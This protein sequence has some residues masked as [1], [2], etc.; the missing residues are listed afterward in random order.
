MGT[1]QARDF[2]R[3][4]NKVALVTGAGSGIGR[5]TALEFS[6]EGARVAVVD[7]NDDAGNATVAAIRA[8]GGDAHFVPADVSREG[9]VKAMVA[10]VVA[11]YGRLDAAFNN[12]GVDVHGPLVTELDEATW[13]KVVDINLKGVFF[14]LKHEIPAMLEHGGGAIV[15]TASVGGVV[16]APRLAAY[17]AAKHGVVGLTRVA[18]LEFAKQGIRVNAVCPGATQSPM[19]EVWLQTPGFADVIRAQHPIG[20]WAQPEEI[21]RAV[22]FLC[23]EDSSFVV[24]T[25]LIVDGGVTCL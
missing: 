3:F 12:A 11:R 25:P 23:A 22:L 8:Q 7:W 6:R 14:C 10:A 4:E 5:A 16:A 9:D 24:G 15:N 20:R 17:I 18:A 13:D 19:L 1:T 21:A 2:R